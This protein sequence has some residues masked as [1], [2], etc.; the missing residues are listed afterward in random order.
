M[1][2]FIRPT[3][4]TVGTKLPSH[5]IIAINDAVDSGNP[6]HEDSH[7]RRHGFGSGL[8]PGVTVYGYCMRTVVALFG[9]EFLSAGVSS[10][11]LRQPFYAGE[12]VSVNGSVVDGMGDG[13]SIEVVAGGVAGEAR[14][15]V[16]A[17]FPGVRRALEPPPRAPLPSP[18]R[19]ATPEGLRAER[20]FGTLECSFAAAD[21]PGFL[22]ALG[23]DHAC[24][25]D[26]VHPAW[27][28][29]QANIVLDRNLALGP[30]VHVASEVEHL[31][32]VRPGE[33]IEVRAEVLEL[34]ARKGHDYADIDVWLGSA[35]R[36]LMRVKHRAI[37]RLA[38]A[39][40]R[41]TA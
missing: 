9:P 1:H 41:A 31:G 7:A 39:P 20:V 38:A 24:Y 14:A 22:A 2:E 12:H 5:S 35:G 15:I 3:A 32:T 17:A 6:I 8:V 13:T 25:R 10:V 19:P 36:P 27:L 23:D 18:R 28:L 29:R 21:G 4:L 16:R 33:R 34:Y 11:Q 26:V 30:W 37:Y 40:D